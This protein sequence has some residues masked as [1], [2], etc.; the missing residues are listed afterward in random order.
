MNIDHPY[1]DPGDG[2]QECWLCG[3]WVWPV[4]HSCKRV[5]MTPDAELRLLAD[6]EKWI[7]RSLAYQR[8]EFVPFDWKNDD[9]RK[10]WDR[11]S[12]RDKWEI[13]IA[14]TPCPRCGVAAGVPCLTR[15]GR[16][17][18]YP[19]SWRLRNARKGRSGRNMPPGWEPHA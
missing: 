14:G 9:R 17:A 1:E 4:L 3:K 5:P 13:E 6:Q 19:H 7:D 8:G 11:L 16:Y 15:A 12:Q 2:R 10:A 18:D